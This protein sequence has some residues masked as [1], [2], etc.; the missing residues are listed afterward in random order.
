MKTLII[1]IIYNYT[2]Y[3]KIYKAIISFTKIMITKS[4]R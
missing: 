4:E 3:A 1:M 2:G